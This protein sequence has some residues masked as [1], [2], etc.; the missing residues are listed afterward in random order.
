[1]GRDAELR[2]SVF[3]STHPR[4][5]R[6][7]RDRRQP[8]RRPFQSTHPRGVRLARVGNFFTHPNPFNPRTRAGCDQFV[9]LSSALSGWLSIHA[10]ARGATAQLKAFAT[11]SKLSIHAPARG[12]TRASPVECVFGTSFNPRTRAG[13]D[14]SVNVEYPN[15]STFNPRTRAGCDQH[16]DPVAGQPRISFNPRTRAGCDIGTTMKEPGTI[17]SFNPRTRAGCDVQ[18]FLQRA[19]RK[20]FQSTHPRGVRRSLFPIRAWRCIFQSTHPRG[21]RH[22]S[23][24]AR[25]HRRSFN[26]RTRAG[27]DANSGRKLSMRTSFNPRTRAGCDLAWMAHARRSQYFQSTHPRGV[28]QIS[29]KLRPTILDF[30]STHPRGVRRKIRDDIR[31]D[32]DL[33]IH[34][35][36]RGATR[37]PPRN[38]GD[39]GV[40]QS[41]HPRGV[42]LQSETSSCAI[43][44]AFNPRTRAG[45]DQ[46]VAAIIKD[47]EEAFNPRTRAGCD[48]S[49][50]SFW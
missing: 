35:P 34:A 1:M 42:R 37:H 24:G 38:W 45:C 43:V 17:F 28:R 29:S 47:H 36:A 10:P 40:F 12:A 41:T 5:V 20:L 14:S 11:I 50:Q 16:A 4:G 44:C 8:H 9:F 15:S 7:R 22:G 26:P 19:K 23:A 18:V 6:Q 13:C 3:Q 49:E 2:A 27:C 39:G 46:I 32:L 33:S 21:V 30:Q 31:I 25:A 48:Q